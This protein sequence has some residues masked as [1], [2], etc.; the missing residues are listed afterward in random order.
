MN[1]TI[2]L[3]G[4]PDDRFRGE[5]K[6]TV[7]PGGAIKREA[8]FVGV[9]PILPMIL[10]DRTLSSRSV[11]VVIGEQQITIPRNAR[12]NI[13]NLIGDADASTGRLRS[14]Q[15]IEDKVRPVRSFNRAA[16]VLKTGRQSLSRTLA[17]VAGCR[18]PRIESLRAPS[19][20]AL[21]QACSAFDHWPL[22]LRAVG[23]HG[24]EHMIVLPD[25]QALDA[26]RETQWL[27]EDVLLIEFVDYQNDQ[28]L[29][30]KHRV[31][32]IDGAPYLRHSITSDIWSIHSGSRSDLMDNDLSLCRQE[33][34]FLAE[35][36]NSGLVKYRDTFEQIYQRIGLDIFGIDFALVDGEILVFEANACMNFLHQNFGADN[37][38]GYLE[39]YVRALKRAIKKML[40]RA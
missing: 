34:T 28:G 7:A 29:Y 32:M 35:F 1:E 39:D 40:M 16:H 2:F 19:F 25:L 4:H 9:L 37:R 26:H 18:V 33:E 6:D 24:G 21:K 11:A 31:I 20:E 13:F 10:R 14:V 36:K 22:I 8:E 27:S 30:K 38:Y 15:K 12:V 3:L 17:G 5:V 23:Y